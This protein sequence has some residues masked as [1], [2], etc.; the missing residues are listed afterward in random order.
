MDIQNIITLIQ[1]VSDAN[2]TNFDM[3]EGSFKLSLNK[4]NNK[5]QVVENN[6]VMPNLQ[7]TYMP[8]TQHI[9][10]SI[11]KNEEDISTNIETKKDTKVDD[12]I[13]EIKSPIVGT[14]Y[15]SSSPDAADF[16]KPG[17]TVRKGETI[18]IIE[19]MKLLNNIESDYEGTIIEVL[20]KNEQ[21]V[22]YNQP[23]FRIKLA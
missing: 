1:A 8:E 2:I 5:I 13:V 21:M 9:I 3:E 20:A 19:A 17:D 4:V 18:C 22:E 12:N 15:S 7:T 16:V 23:L 6:Q 14:F 11:N 10:E